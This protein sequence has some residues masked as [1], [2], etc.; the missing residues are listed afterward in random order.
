MLTEKAS[1]GSSGAMSL[2][3][4]VKA[5]IMAK[6]LSDLTKE[7]CEQEENL[8]VP[9]A[10]LN[11][12][13]IVADRD[14]GESSQRKCYCSLVMSNFHI[15]S[16]TIIHNMLLSSPERRNIQGIRNRKGIHLHN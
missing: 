2:K 16:N 14:D 13:G 7:K 8:I 4:T 1:G 10:I 9:D 12:W 5:M 6:R 11:R 15:S 3:G